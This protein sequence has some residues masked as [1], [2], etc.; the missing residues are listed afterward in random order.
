[1]DMEVEWVMEQHQLLHRLPRPHLHQPRLP[2]QLPP[3]LHQRR[4]QPQPP[5]PVDT[6]QVCS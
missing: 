3:H 5:R 6:V 2:H 4:H 1:M